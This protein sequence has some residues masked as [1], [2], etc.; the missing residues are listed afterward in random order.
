[1]TL[2]ILL[3]V[4]TWSTAYWQ[5][6]GGLAGLW[7]AIPERVLQHGELWRIL[8][9]AFVHSDLSHLLSNALGLGVLSFLTFGYYGFRVTPLLTLGLAAAANLIVMFTYS[10][11]VR[12]VGA[13]GWVYTL[14]GFWLVQFICL[15]R[16]YTLP[17]RWMRAV[18]VALA[19]MGPSTYEPGVSYRTHVVGF[20]LG[21]VVSWFYFRIHRER[22]RSAE[23]WV[24]TS[25]ERPLGWEEQADASSNRSRPS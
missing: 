20:F 14:A 7:S 4:A 2:G 17:G 18:A 23:E 8:T 22:L 6:W 12:L 9:A 3:W 13:S 16:Q 5:D 11:Q 10:P 15:Q 21:A 25:L 24:L 19:T 1:M